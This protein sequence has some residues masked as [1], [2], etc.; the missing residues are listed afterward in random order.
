MFERFIPSNIIEK[1]KNIFSQINLFRKAGWKFHSNIILITV[2]ASITSIVVYILACKAVDID[3]PIGLLAWQCILIYLLGCLPIS[4]ANL[5]VREFTL[6]E[7]LSKYNIT[8]S[9]AL[10]MSMVLFS[11]V[12]F[13]ALLG[14][15]FQLY[16][17][18]KASITDNR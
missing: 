10:M 5:G 9:Q 1:I 2:L 12:I 18:T 3:V 16:W 4:F 14:A 15:V 13:M 6:I 11:N 7:M 8:S 17:F